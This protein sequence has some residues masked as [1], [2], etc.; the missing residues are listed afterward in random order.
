MRIEIWSDIVCPFCYIGKRNFEQALE[1]FDGAAEVEIIWRSFELSPGIKTDPGRS[2]YEFLA[3]KKGWSLEQSREMHEQVVKAAQQAGLEF[4]FDKTVPVNS[5]NAHRLMHLATK[6]G[7]QNELQE[8]LFAAY[9][10]D[11]MNVDDMDTLIS[12]GVET[13]LPEEDI[14]QTLESNRYSEEVRN[15]VQE[16]RLLGVQ[17]VPFFVFD[18][19]YAVSGA[20]PPKV[21][22]ETMEKVQQQ[23]AEEQ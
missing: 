4:N 17:G 5:F 7:L 11:G 12:L 2:I 21:F 19:T 22:L 13:G 14:R 8:R 1:K 16:A 6:R 18:R 15:D 9:F 20:Q 10:T 23:K 3:E